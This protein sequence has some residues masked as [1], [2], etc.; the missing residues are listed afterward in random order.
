VRAQ[1][2]LGAAT[3]LVWRQ[4]AMGVYL[5][6]ESSQER[7]AGWSRAGA[8]VGGAAPGDFRRD[9]PVDVLGGYVASPPSSRWEVTGWS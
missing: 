7:L 6:L 4:I 3:T 2:V 9:S 5:L 8:P 1:G